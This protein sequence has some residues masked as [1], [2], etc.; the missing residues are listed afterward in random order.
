VAAGGK[1]ILPVRFT[2]PGPGPRDGTIRLQFVG[3]GKAQEVDLVLHAD[4]EKATLNLLTPA[5][6]FTDTVPHR[7]RTLSAWLRN[8][9]T[10]TSVTV[11]GVTGLPAEFSTSFT[12]STIPPGNDLAVPITYTP[13]TRGTH[14][15]NVSIKNNVGAALNIHVS[16]NTATWPTE[17]ITDFGDVPL[18]SGESDWLEVDVP[19]DA[20]SL[21]IEALGPV[22][23]IEFE[24]PGGKVYVGVGG[25]FEVTGLGSEVMAAI[26]PPDDSSD[27]QLVPDGGIYRFRIRHNNAGMLVGTTITCPVRAIVENRLD[28]VVDGG[29]LDMNFFFSPGLGVS[30][31]A[32]D[33]KVAAVITRMG[34]IFAQ[35]NLRMG[36]VSYFTLTDSAWDNV[37]WGKQ[38]QLFAESKVAPEPRV[39]VFFVQTVSVGGPWIGLAAMVPGVKRNGTK[40]SG[41]VVDY[42]YGDAAAT[43]QIAVHEV[44]HYLGLWHV[45]ETDNAMYKELWVA[46]L[47]ILTS[48]QEYVVLRHPLVD[49]D[50]LP[51]L[52][53]LAQMS[54]PKPVTFV[55][56][57]GDFCGS[58]AASK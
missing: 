5:L 32:T 17:L 36:K 46:T 27:N 26:V 38:P 37:E 56:L 7:Q 29:V 49:P 31:P 19:P 8:D 22:N 48:S 16:A 41:V 4:V 45:A 1:V 50:T 14:D 47:P 28:A 30:N 13:T 12:P 25:G 20:I 23:L 35:V 34:D 2:P 6:A 58:C 24:G 51:S 15:F 18:V 43:G 54:A 55:Q 57:P 52:S 39:N 3:G 33:S 10:L 9:N 21:S 11:T 42:D 40:G 44:G 53:A